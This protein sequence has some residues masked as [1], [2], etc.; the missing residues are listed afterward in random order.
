M[1]IEADVETEPEEDGEYDPTVLD[2]LT[3][4]RDILQAFYRR[5]AELVEDGDATSPAALDEGSELPHG[6]TLAQTDADSPEP[7]EGGTPPSVSDEDLPP[8]EGPNG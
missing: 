7:D 3:F 6:H 5:S 8:T 2:D 4:G 1:E